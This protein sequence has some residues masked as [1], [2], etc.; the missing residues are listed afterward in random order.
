[1]LPLNPLPGL[2]IQCSPSCWLKC[3]VEAGAPGQPS[4]LG[5][6]ATNGGFSD[7]STQDFPNSIR[8][9]RCTAVGIVMSERMQAVAHPIARQPHKSDAQ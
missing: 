6:V 4:Q 8:T 3:S 7:W 2:M 9:V 5:V 1:V